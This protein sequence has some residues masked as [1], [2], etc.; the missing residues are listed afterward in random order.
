MKL[1]KVRDQIESRLIRL[2]QRIDAETG[3]DTH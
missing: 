3:E 2:G 1:S